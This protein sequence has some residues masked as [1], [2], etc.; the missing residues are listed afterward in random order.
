MMF[1]NPGMGW[2]TGN[3]DIAR[4]YA[5]ANRSPIFLLETII[6]KQEEILLNSKSGTACMM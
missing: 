4:G 3:E 5:K 2:A 1:Y 6:R